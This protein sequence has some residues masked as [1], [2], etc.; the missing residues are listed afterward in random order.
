MLC[1]ESSSHRDADSRVVDSDS[2]RMTA[3]SG[4]ALIRLYD[5]S[6]TELPTLLSADARDCL[7]RL[8][9]STYSSEEEACF[10]SVAV[11]LPLICMAEGEGVPQGCRLKPSLAP[12][13]TN[14]WQ[15][16]TG[17]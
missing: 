2:S 1:I 14:V 16:G 11:M 8:R 7:A 9:R 13:S 12:R 5:A 3:I 17:A 10:R 15:P 6:A 4:E